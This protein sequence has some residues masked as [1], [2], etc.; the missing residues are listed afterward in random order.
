MHDDRPLLDFDHTTTEYQQHAREIYGDL[1]ARCPV[2]WSENHGGYWVL[3]SYDAV[4][5]ALRDHET[6]SSARY[7]DEQGAWHGGLA[8]PDLQTATLLP[9]HLDPP[10]WADYRRILNPWLSPT[11]VEEARDRLAAHATD[12]LDAVVETGHCDLIPVLGNPL[13]AIAT[14][15]LIGIEVDDWDRWAQP[16]HAI[17]YSPRGSAAFEQAMLDLT[18]QREQLVDA[19]AARRADPRDDMLSAVATA[20]VGDDLITLD[21]AAALL[22][23]VI[24]GGVS[25]STALFA[26]SVLHLHRHPDQRRWLLDDLDG[27]LPAALEEFLRVYPPVPVVARTIAKDGAMGGF[28]QRPRERVAI[29]VLSAN[30]DDSEFDDPDE[31][32]L[33]RFPNRHA[34][35]GIGIHRCVG[36]YVARTIVRLMLEQVLRRTPDFAVDESAMVRFGPSSTIDG[37]ISLPVTFTPSRRTKPA[38]D[39]G[40]RS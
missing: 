31:I 13:P 33:D 20:R 38:T 26:N 8:I 3:S 35:F 22:S 30:H 11:R 24:S 18:W 17:Q 29:S 25:S 4:W 36:S 6:F 34:T 9:L 19:L 5:N 14:L 27:R 40:R 32:R 10:Q 15:E 1:R 21:D 16:H 7:K 37:W 12:L 23:T 39:G 28:H 2:G